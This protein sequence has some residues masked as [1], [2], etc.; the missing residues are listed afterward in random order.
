MNET[1]AMCSC[2]LLKGVESQPVIAVAIDGKPSYMCLRCS[3]NV[4][5]QMLLTGKG[6]RTVASLLNFEQCGHGEKHA[7]GVCYLSFVSRL[8]MICAE[9]RL[10]GNEA[11]KQLRQLC[12]ALYERHSVPSAR[13]CTL[14]QRTRKR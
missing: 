7:C 9:L 6:Y 11:Y 3:V 4:T 12:Q 2:L 14:D 1:V 10:A 8:Q 13:Y 5:V